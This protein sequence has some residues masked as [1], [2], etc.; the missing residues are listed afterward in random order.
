MKTGYYL[1]PLGLLGEKVIDRIMI[2]FLR[3]GFNAI[4]W[5]DKS[6]KM[7]FHQAVYKKDKR[8]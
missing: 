7:E 1:T 5:N 6:K 3:T 4:V 8:K 2:N